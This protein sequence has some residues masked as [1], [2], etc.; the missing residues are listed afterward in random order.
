MKRKLYSYAL[1]C[2]MMLAGQAAWADL[3]QNE[4]GAY[5][6]GSKA[7]LQAWSEMAGYESTDVV[8]TS[9]IEGLDF[10]LCTNTTSYSGTFDGAGHTI[11][12]NYDFEGKQTG[13]F[14]NFAGTVKN[15]IVGGYIRASFKNCA[16]LAAW[17]WSDNATF[18]NVA[19]IVSIDVDYEANASNAGFIG[20]AA[21]NAIFRN[22]ISAP[23]DFWYDLCDEMG[24]LI[25]DEYPFWKCGSEPAHEGRPGWPYCDCNDN[26]LFPELLA[27]VRERGTHPSIAVIDLQNESVYD[28]FDALAHKLSVHAAEQE[29]LAKARIAVDY[30]PVIQ[31]IWEEPAVVFAL[32]LYPHMQLPLG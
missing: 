24:L 17:N 3:Q 18:E 22:C 13:M 26:T 20:Y 25:Q 27:W 28:W 5:L 11:T 21:R 9:D 7:D 8:L 1:A 14:Y 23:P 4:D 16:G 12:L 10:M 30:Q 15:L 19:S 2:I 29:G 31:G 32:L 6:I